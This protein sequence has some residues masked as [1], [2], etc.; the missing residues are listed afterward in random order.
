[1]MFSAT[2]AGRRARMR[3]K[4]VARFIVY[5][6]FPG[7]VAIAALYVAIAGMIHWD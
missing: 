5:R 6:A 7:I 2:H 1:M 4:R 3:L